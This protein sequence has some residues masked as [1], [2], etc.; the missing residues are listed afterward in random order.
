MKTVDI[1]LRAYVE[2]YI[3]RWS[4]RPAITRQRSELLDFLTAHRS[5]WWGCEMSADEILSYLWWQ[6]RCDERTLIIRLANSYRH[7]CIRHGLQQETI[8]FKMQKL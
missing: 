5:Q 6:C 8:T 3:V 1:T 4:D 2:T 7:Y